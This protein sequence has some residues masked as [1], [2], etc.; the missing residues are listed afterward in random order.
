MGK[1][2]D[3]LA[4][5]G[6]GGDDFTKNWQS[7]VAADE[8]EPLP[9]GEYVATIQ[10]GELT[11]VGSKDTPSYKLTFRVAEGDHA[12]RLFWHDVWLTRAALPQAKRDLAKLG[13]TDPTQLERAIPIGIVCKVRLALRRDDDGTERNRVQR[14]EVLRIETPEADPY[15]PLYGEEDATDAA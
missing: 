15:A 11:T 14:F 5:G 8:F 7:T 10:H 6:F 1:L 4:A 2:T 13:V 3:I 12:D 9:T